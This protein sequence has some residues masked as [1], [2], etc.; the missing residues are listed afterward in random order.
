MPQYQSR[1][2]SLSRALSTRVIACGVTAVALSGGLMIRQS[3]AT[4]SAGD[5]TE[6]SAA[7][8]EGATQLSQAFAEWNRA[9]RLLADD[10]AFLRW[11]NDPASRAELTA[12][13][14][15]RFTDLDTLYPGIVDEACF[16]D[17]KGPEL[18]REVKGVTAPVSDLS[19][20]ESK[21][22]FFGATF[23]LPVGFVHQNIPYV[24]ADSKR[25]VVSNSTPLE[26]NGNQVALVHFEVS[27]ES[28]RLR[29]K[30]SLPEGGRIRVIDDRS[31]AVVVDT[32]SAPI[33]AQDFANA[34]ANPLKGGTASV[35]SVEPENGNDN[36]WTVEA[37]VPTSP[38][39]S[40]STW[41]GLIGLAA[42]VII[43]LG[44]VTLRFS[45]QLTRRLRNVADVSDAVASGDLSY[46]VDV[47]RNDELGAAAESINKAVDVLADTIGAVNGTAQR[48]GTSST[49][50][51]SSARQVSYNVQT[52][53]AGTE[54]LTASVS[55][56]ARSATDAA[57]TATEAVDLARS[58][59]ESVARLTAVSGSIGS[60]V[61]LIAGIAEQT[62]LL[63]LNATIESARAGE[64][65]RG[66]AVVANEVKELAQETAKATEEIRQQVG[67]IQRGTDHASEAIARISHVISS[68]HGSQTVIAAAV[69][70]QSA[71]AAEMGRQLVEAA[72]VTTT[73]A[74]GDGNANTASTDH[75]SRMALELQDLVSAFTNS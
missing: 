49:A 2:L 52:V 38:A 51:T 29:L 8:H 23:D 72:S 15:Q 30:E 37:W 68:I 58:A 74:E 36:H 32:G 46:R 59:S 12:H 22:D 65:G 54:Q 26:I 33:D 40:G 21:S 19:P 48:L 27:L 60:V 13:I 20:D 64:A 50:L 61:D 9:L 71:T 47:V 11:Y 43:I 66:F 53:A 10:Q 34:T 16:I 28:L 44:F 63:A 31:G 25:W 4:A 42:A 1:R 41:L 5:R 56:I 62:N 6:S 18:A 45:R 35:A 70:E 7:A 57:A 75:L 39:V 69:E 17:R 3:S 24:S 55:E 73:M 14:D 67:A